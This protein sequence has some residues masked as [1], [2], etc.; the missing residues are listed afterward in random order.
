MPKFEEGHKKL[1]GRKAGTPNKR[2]QEFLEVLVNNDFCPA[3]AMVEVF[4]RAKK[5]YEALTGKVDEHVKDGVSGVKITFGQDNAHHYLRIMADMAKELQSYNAPKL[6]SIEHK[7]RGP[8][9]DM[10]DEDKLAAL[11]AAVK[12]ME[13]EIKEKKS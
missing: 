12:F 3:S 13:A 10:S 8:L 9:D 5:R 7:P 11:K 6:K 1:G 4:E 2:T